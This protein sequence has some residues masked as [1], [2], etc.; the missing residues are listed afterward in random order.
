MQ[1]LWLPS[2]YLRS[3]FVIW[4]QVDGRGVQQVT[5]VEA[6]ALRLDGLGSLWRG[7]NHLATK[8]PSPP[9]GT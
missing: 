1:Q 6:L 3:S 7:R 4:F 9:G 2:I 5:N 8:A